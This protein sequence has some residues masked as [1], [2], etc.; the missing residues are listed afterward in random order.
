MD[1]LNDSFS[2]REGT[3]ISHFTHI[4]PLNNDNFFSFTVEEEKTP[5][6]NFKLKQVSPDEICSDFFEGINSWSE[7]KIFN[8]LNY[9]F[10]SKDIRFSNAGD[11]PLIEGYRMAYLHHFPIV[12]NPSH[13]WLMI[14]QGFSKH[15]EIENNSE[16]NRDKF[17]NFKGQKNIGIET[18]INLFTASDEQWIAFIEKLL[19]ETKKNLKKDGQ[20]FVGLLKKKFSTST[21]ESEVA[22]NVTILSSFKKYFVYTMAGTCGISKIRIE[23]T[24]EDWDLL[25]NKVEEIERFDND[26]AF[27]TKELKYIIQKII[28]TLK[29]KEPDINFYKNIVQ[30]TDKSM[31]CK[32][33]LVNG[34][35]IKFIPYDCHGKKCNFNSPD[36]NGLAIDEIP[37]QITSLPFNLKNINK[38][39]QIKN[40]DAEI[41]SGFFGIKQD[42]ETLAIKPIIGYAI[43]EVKDKKLEE[44]KKMKNDIM[45]FRILSQFN[46]MNE[47]EIYNHLMM[48]EN[49]NY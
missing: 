35:I 10:E 30:N 49:K 17:V 20:D 31:E 9:S 21:R 27:W 37:T 38:K 42:K 22:N 3:Q 46:R 16:K 26:I 47:S 15:M 2:T 34:W 23:G 25:L 43:V 48:N 45:K 29:T 14:L 36:F 7:D 1:D 33:D 32:P 19:D 5:D 12:I 24:N 18:G 6:V 39:G 11:A 40:Y 13:F 44:Q 4:F 41:Y 8:I 28:D